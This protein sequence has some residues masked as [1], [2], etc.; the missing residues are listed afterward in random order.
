MIG[1]FIVTG[2]QAKEVLLRAIGPSLASAGV[3]GA[4]V[5]PAME[6]YD[7]AGN[8][9]NQN[10]DAGSIPQEIVAAGLAPQNPAESLIKTRFLRVPTPSS[11]EA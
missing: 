5:D 8:L 3:S 6:L 1:G 10:D 11:S 4:L 2:T 9:I 7:L